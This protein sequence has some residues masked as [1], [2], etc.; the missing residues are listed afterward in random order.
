MARAPSRRIAP[1]FVVSC[2]AL[3]NDATWRAS[4][5]ELAAMV[6]YSTCPL[7]AADKRSDL[8]VVTKRLAYAY[9]SYHQ[10]IGTFR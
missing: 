1:S 7:P 9:P 4:D 6:Q 3:I 10:G 8:A 5:D 2:R